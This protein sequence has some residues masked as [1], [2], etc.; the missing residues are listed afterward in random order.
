M[1]L[2]NHGISQAAIAKAFEQSRQFFALPLV[3]KRAIAWSSETKNRGYVGVERDRLDETKPGE[4][5]EAFNV[6]REMPFTG[7]SDDRQ[8]LV[9]NQW[10]DGHDEFKTSE[11][12]INPYQ[13]R[14]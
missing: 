14:R 3:E 13:I 5:K 6:G 9:V 1:Y 10:P 12:L 2:K 7:L 4:L 8:A 11:A